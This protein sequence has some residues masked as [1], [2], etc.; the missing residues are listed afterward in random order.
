[1]KKSLRKRQQSNSAV[2][3]ITVAI[4]SLSILTGCII[5]ISKNN[6]RSVVD[7]PS[8]KTSNNISVE[9]EPEE[10][11]DVVDSNVET[12]VSVNEFSKS[13][14]H[15]TDDYIE[16]ANEN[17]K[18]LNVA[19]PKG[20]DIFFQSPS[21]EFQSAG[22]DGSVDS[23]SR[24]MWVYSDK[25]LISTLPPLTFSDLGASSCGAMPP[26]L[27][28][29]ATDNLNKLDF[30]NIDLS[31]CQTI[32][33]YNTESL[34]YIDLGNFK[35]SVAEEEVLQY[36]DKGCVITLFNGMSAEAV[37]NIKEINVSSEIMAKWV[38]LEATSATVKV[39]GSVYDFDIK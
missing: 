18:Q 32:E 24:Y 3:Y 28:I 35:S 5:F 25:N 17:M 2:L 11:F 34:E 22:S 39:N 15:L 14:Y 4:I 19:P 12:E 16:F 8:P 31:W 30:S 29:Y 6:N 20:T 9:L 7:I 13:D 26:E 1:M 36:S 21:P 38:H 23:C 33:L 10:T 27:I 37:N